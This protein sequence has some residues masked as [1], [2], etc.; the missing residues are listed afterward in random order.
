MT[1]VS[2]DFNA[3]GNLRSYNEDEIKIVWN[4]KWLNKITKL[5][6][7]TIF[8][9]EGL[10]DKFKDKLPAR[11][12]GEVVLVAGTVASG[13][14]DK[15]RALVEKDYVVGGK[16]YHLFPGDLLPDGAAYT[17]SEVYKEYENVICKVYVKLPPYM[18][19]FEVG[20]S[21]FNPKSLTE[22]HYLTW[23]HNTLETL[24]NYP[25]ITV[26]AA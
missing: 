20:T 21:F 9:V 3:Y 10:M 7:P 16:T 11:Y 15:I 8:N 5:D 6:L 18:S 1:D 17:G 24:K 26:R 23:G 22:N 12:F 13:N 2:R 14:P 4:A 25:F 19:A